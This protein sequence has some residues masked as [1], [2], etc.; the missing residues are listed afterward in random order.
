[1]K[2]S[3]WS[4]L[5][6]LALALAI[7]LSLIPHFGLDAKA[8]DEVY[9]TVE[10][11]FYLP[12]NDLTG[13]SAYGGA[14]IY[15]N[16]NDTYEGGTAA[17]NPVML[18]QQAGAFVEYNFDLEDTLAAATLKLS[19]SGGKVEVKPE[20]G[21]FV[22][23]T[24]KNG[25]GFNRGTAIYD[26]TETDALAADNNC[27]TLRISSSGETVILNGLY[28]QTAPMV[29][30]SIHVIPMIGEG[31]LNAVETVSSG[32]GRYFAN[33]N[34]PTLYLH[35][36]ESVAFHVQVRSDATSTRIDYANLGNALSAEI[37]TDGST[38]SAL[39]NGSS[40]TDHDLYLRFTASAG[41]AFLT[42]VTLSPV[43][44]GYTD[45]GTGVFLPQH[46]LTGAHA[47][48]GSG[49]LG[50]FNDQDIGGS[51]AYNTVLLLQ[52]AGD[53]V[54][55]NFDMDD[56]LTN[57]MLKISITGGK[58][59]V[60]PDGGEF[61]TLTPA[62]GSG[63]NRGTAVYNL[64]EA[65]AL[66]AD[67]NCFTLRI[68]HDGSTVILNGMAVC[69]ELVTVSNALSIAAL[70]EGY[71]KALHT[72]SSGAGRYFLN[73]NTPTV[74]L[75]TGESVVF[76]VKVSE[77]AGSAKIDYTHAG[78]ELTM[79]VSGDG[80]TW[81]TLEKNGETK[82]KDLY[83]RFTM[84][85][86]EGFLQNVT[87]TPIDPNY[88]EIGTG[89]YMPLNDLNGAANFGG[90]IAQNFNDTYQGGNETVA[91]PTLLLQQ[92]GDFVE[93]NLDM[94]DALTS[95]VMKLGI[96][97]GKV[98]VKPE[99]GEF[100]TLTAANGTAFD[101][102]TA[103]YTLDNTNALKAE[104]NKFILRI[105]FDGSATVLN[106]LL[107]HTDVPRIE[108]ATT[109][110]ALGESYL[111]TLHTVSGGATRYF[112]D[113]NVP[114]LFLHSGESVV[115]HVKINE[116]AGS[117]K[118]EFDQ[119]G[120]AMTMEVSPDGNSW[121]ALDN[122]GDTKHKEL[123]IR[124]TASSGDASFL[125]S[126]TVTPLAP[127][128]TNI[129]SGIFMH[130]KDL[131][132]AATYG[133]S[134]ITGN[135]NDS[136]NG[137]GETVANPVLLLTAAGNFVEYNFD[138]DDALTS[139]IMKLNISGGKVEIKPAGAEEYITMT[140]VNG[141]AFNR[142][143]AI[144]QLD[145]T[146]ALSG[147]SNKFSLRISSS[148]ETVI[149]NALL[150]HTDVTTLTGGAAIPMM[151]EEFLRAVDNVSA[152]VTRYFL[153]G[154]TATLHMHSS[155]SVV[156]HF[157]VNNNEI[158]NMQV[159]FT[160][161][162]QPLTL[163]VSTDGSTWTP[164]ENGE[165]ISDK[166]FYLRF[167]A[168]VG[169]AF[170]SG[171]TLTPAEPDAKEEQDY[172]YIPIKDLS[173]ADN[174]SG[175]G[176]Y[177]N[178]ED[179]HLDGA[180]GQTGNLTLL[181]QKADDYVDYDFNLTDSRTSALLKVY[182]TDAEVYV[183]ASGGEFV[184][185]TAVNDTG[186][187]FNRG[188]AIFEL[189][190]SNALANPNRQFT[191]RIRAK[192][193][194]T[195]V[196]N[197]MVVEAANA[198]FADNAFN[199]DPL[200]E[201]YLQ[202]IVDTR[203]DTSRYFYQRTIPAVFLKQDGYVTFRMNFD[204]DGACYLL[205]YDA[206]GQPL[207]AEVSL[208][209]STWVP[210]KGERVDK[211]L[212]MTGTG[213][214]YIRF[215]AEEGESFLVGMHASRQTTVPVLEGNAN[216][217]APKDITNAFFLVGTDAEKKYIFGTGEDYLASFHSTHTGMGIAGHEGGYSGELPPN[218][219]LFNGGSVT[220]EFDLADSITT[221][222]LKVYGLAGMQFLISTDEGETYDTITTESAPSGSGRGYYIFRLDETNALRGEN[223]KFR[224]QIKG[225]YGVLIAMM[226]ETGTPSV[227]NGG[228]FFTPTSESSLLYLDSTKDLRTYYA[229]L[230]FPN[231]FLDDK[232]ELTFRVPMSSSVKSAILYATYCSDV[233]ISVATSR[234]GTYTTLL[235]SAL[236]S[237]GTP[238]TNTMDVSQYLGGEAL[239][240]RFTGSA[241]C[242]FVD[243]FGIATNP[244][245]RTSDTINAYG[246]S[247][248]A[249]LF[250][251][252]TNDQGIGTAKRVTVGLTKGRAIDV[253]GAVI[254]RID[255]PDDAEGVDLKLDATGKY[256]ISGSID[257]VNFLPAMEVDAATLRIVEPLTESDSRVLY[258]KI[259]NASGT[260][261]LILRSLSY[262]LADVPN[263]ERPETPDFD[264]DK[265]LPDT[266]PGVEKLETPTEPAP[267][268]PENPNDPTTSEPSVTEPKT[269][270]PWVWICTGGVAVLAVILLIVILLARRK[271]R[272]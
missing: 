271:K 147:E 210:L 57:A 203:Q 247:E 121:S 174:Y 266:F 215:T 212:D 162:G 132:G 31:F 96:T 175:D 53:F 62:N 111:R 115:F 165:C 83:I 196:L 42:G 93:Y 92:T 140:P 235:T 202:A 242:A 54:E 71:L 134:G 38:W 19:I 7:C 80:S 161:A 139:A 125:K 95:A 35:D 220:Y 245:E 261:D 113:G 91:N 153:N 100:V 20:G 114:A 225:E 214:F 75:H 146:N 241:A 104:S 130:I 63:F 1:M 243:C 157:R 248:S 22:V 59:E 116:A 27:F 159:D 193:G 98:E 88:T 197:G 221:A 50:D 26:L 239:Y 180:D 101:R 97:A 137:G 207:T 209:G 25:S 154:D 194:A 181:L 64:T 170:L 105:S 28:I 176:L 127:D 148:G 81:E 224:L 238:H 11:D 232:T 138:M 237:T 179:T 189:N 229:E 227:G 253:G 66:A 99:G 12:L 10:G 168:S 171:V 185:L 45:I 78:A 205:T 86:G 172:M 265:D 46:N 39:T 23:L 246:G 17:S 41:A 109:I 142:G 72:V 85:E 223:N 156:F 55:Y 30:S 255:L 219:R 244:S 118:V 106:G 70:G 183:R 18:L 268:Y 34:Q 234:N 76:H 258:V 124:L 51:A 257:G 228:V 29:I 218:A 110:P 122:G 195:A 36:G 69:G 240:I 44:P 128:F 267:I 204:P 56:S 213:T 191:V 8:T 68:S 230:A 133:G 262:A 61:S 206:V 192:D 260:D 200:G 2:N 77:D 131:E 250:R 102:G 73:G 155:E 40:V 190:E 33:S 201:S 160:Q 164:L 107:I 14:G 236:G 135:F 254:Y 37:S 120:A 150:I 13:T 136:F 216:P 252:E 211:A 65:D 249:H 184:K 74:F 173:N 79:E 82:H 187:R 32:A 145:E 108:N 166:D 15:G 58:V 163:E 143:T 94:D 4:K 226:I 222:D 272:E 60:K 21:E 182:M 233:T 87:V 67:N 151:G 178:F 149:I 231:Y 6:S 129:G 169:E 188:V 270:T 177:S 89:I 16:F 3:I 112:A 52:N 269:E 199:L 158:R 208:N 217:N 119:V 103:V 256:E 123:Y 49:I 126:L 186:D 117:T 47:C 141:T 251:I 263:M 48:G 167:T 152:G 259:T 144:Y 264:Y 90:S 24:A 5:I 198:P 84:P 43:I 9:H